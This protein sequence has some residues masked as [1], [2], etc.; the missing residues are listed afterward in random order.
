MD[1]QAKQR[2]KLEL[3]SQFAR[4]GKVLA[5]PRRLE[6]LDLLA[7]SEH[8]VEHL[9]QKTGMSVANTSQHLQALR[10]AQLVSVR[11]DGTYMYYQLADES[12]LR[13]WNAIVQF[14]QTRLAEIDRLMQ[15][16]VEERS[17]LETI[18]AEELLERLKEGNII[19]LDARPEDE[20]HA[21]HLPGAL[22]IPI[23]VLEERLHSLPPNQ[24]LVAYCRNAYCLL[25]DELASA[26]HQK[27]YHI[28]KL[29]EGVTEWQLAGLPLE[30][31]PSDSP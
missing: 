17:A 21:G 29:I 15:T 3:Y 30:S 22:S 7:Q 23:E 9:A 16:F 28:K 12:V 11:R 18:T 2:F 20:Y 27:G 10:A 4:V 5:N 19:L 13:V 8:S 24:E 6:I 26:L 25:S 31:D 1:K 14:A